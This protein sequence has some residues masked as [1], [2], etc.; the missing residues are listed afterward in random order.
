M[1][2]KNGRTTNLV[3][4]KETNAKGGKDLRVWGGLSII[5]KTKLQEKGHTVQT[6]K[7][8]KRPKN[9]K[10]EGKNWVRGKS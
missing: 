3:L 4:R 6:K 5:K 2:A 8:R 7:K 10:G 9:K 1:G